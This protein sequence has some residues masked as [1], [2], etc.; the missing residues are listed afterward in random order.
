MEGD[1][2]LVGDLTHL[3]QQARGVLPRHT[4]LALERDAAVLGRHRNAHEKLQVLRSAGLLDDLVEL[5]LSVEREALHAELPIG[6]TN[7]APRLHR[8]HEMDLRAG[9]G[10]RILEFRQ[11]SNVE[12]ADAGPVERPEQKHGAVRLVGVRDLTGKVLEEPAGGAAGSMGPDTE[13]GAIGL[14]AADQRCRR[15]ESFHLMGPP[16]VD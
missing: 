14:R 4:E 6:A 9:D 15:C 3:H 10:C 1:P 13:H 7:R 2:K 12:L 16:P 11:G 5:V 8:M